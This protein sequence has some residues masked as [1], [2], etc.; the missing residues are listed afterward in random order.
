MLESGVIEL[1]EGYEWISP[2]IV[3]KK[4]QGLNTDLCILE[5]VK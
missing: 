2:M 1:V 3:Q 5:E 4:K